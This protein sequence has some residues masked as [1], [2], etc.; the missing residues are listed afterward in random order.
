MFSNPWLVFGDVGIWVLTCVKLEMYK[1]WQR[2]RG[3]G[4]VMEK[5]KII[6]LWIP[7]KIMHIKSN[8]AYHDTA[9]PLYEH[10]LWALAYLNSNLVQVLVSDFSVWL[11]PGGELDKGV[12]Q[13]KFIISAKQPPTNAFIKLTNR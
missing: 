3:K 5:N 11:L 4:Y 2:Q 6:K 8:Y 12:A 10:G 9:F 13:V 7:N 1:L